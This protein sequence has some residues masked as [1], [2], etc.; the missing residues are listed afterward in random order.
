MHET[1]QYDKIKV[2]KNFKL[3][4]IPGSSNM[5]WPA[6][7]ENWNWKPKWGRG[8]KFYTMNT[9]KFLILDLNKIMTYAI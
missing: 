9:A 5:R 7:I 8:F 4:F 6:K 2:L 1:R 3:G